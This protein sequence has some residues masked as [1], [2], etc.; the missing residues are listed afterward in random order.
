MPIT[1]LEAHFAGVPPI[2][3]GWSRAR[4]GKGRI[5]YS[6][7]NLLH[8]QRP[9]MIVDE[10]HNAVTGLSEEM[11]KRVNPCAIIEFTATP[12]ENSNILYSV[13]AQELKREEMI[14]LPIVLA[15]HKDWQSAVSSAIETRA[16]LAQKARLDSDDYIRPIVLFQ[17]QPK[18]QDVTVETLKSYLIENENIAPEK[19]AVAT[20]D[21]RELDGIN[22]FD[23]KSPIEF[24]I[25]V[26]ALKEGWD[27]SFAYVFCS[28]SRIRS[29]TAVEQLLGRVLRM[30]YAR[31]R[32]LAELNKAYAHVAEPDFAEAAKSLVDK[33]VE[34]G[35]DDSEARDS[36][37]SEQYELG[38]D[39]CS[40]RAPS[41][42]RCL[43]RI[44]PLRQRQLKPCSRRRVLR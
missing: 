17:A 13:T 41:R 40:G 15:E 37:E 3:R 21:Q 30:P 7:A 34:M 22:L 14:K 33:L 1:D 18:D 11:Q 5:K 39:V 28:V 35:F 43:G 27:C 16:M 36:I 6:F 29:A 26:D 20:G 24:V 12:K 23:P 10:A 38:A 8:L 32:K 19:T 2:F 4:L 9:L 44:S 31:T 25:T 42:R